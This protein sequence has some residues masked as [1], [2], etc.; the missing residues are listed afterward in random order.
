MRALVE[1]LRADGNRWMVLID[2]ERF[3]LTADQV[4]AETSARPL[5][6]RVR[7]TI[8]HELAHS[9]TFRVSEL[10][11]SLRPEF[12]PKK[13]DA[14]WVEQVERVTEKLSPLMLMP[15]ESI[16]AKVARLPSPLDMR[17]LKG[18]QQDFAVS[19]EVLVNRFRMLRENDPDM[20]LELPVLRDVGL[21]IG[22][23]VTSRRA[24]L[25]RWPVFVNY[26]RNVTPKCFLRRF[27]DGTLDAGTLLEDPNMVVNGGGAVKGR[28]SSRAGLSSQLDSDVMIVTSEIE[29]V[30]AVGGANFLYLESRAA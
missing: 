12:S 5:P 7:N 24:V 22:K 9:L 20:L 18:L 4:N 21:G 23:W 25:K 16:A 8:A 29:G 11:T 2:S 17:Q 28:W 30:R 10:G 27:A 14:T 1:R 15:R 26:D 6:T 3:G 19:R 13:Q